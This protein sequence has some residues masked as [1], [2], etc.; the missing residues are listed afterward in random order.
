LW[1]GGVVVSGNVVSAFD[2]LI[3]RRG[4]ACL[5]CCLKLGVVNRRDRLE[6]KPRKG[7]LN[8]LNPI[9]MLLGLLIKSIEFALLNEPCVLE[10]PFCKSVVF[11]LYAFVF[12]LAHNDVERSRIVGAR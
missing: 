2:G 10:K 5:F 3:L 11:P 1:S 4:A 7:F 6:L 8:T 12:S 9:A